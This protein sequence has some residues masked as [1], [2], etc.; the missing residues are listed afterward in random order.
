MLIF[1]GPQEAWAAPGRASWVQ[2]NLER[3]GILHSWPSLRSD[4]S[5]EC[6]R[7]DITPQSHNQEMREQSVSPTRQSWQA[8]LNVKH[9]P[10]ARKA[11]NPF[12]RVPAL[13]PEPSLLVRQSQQVEK[14]WPSFP[15]AN[16]RLL[17]YSILLLISVAATGLPLSETGILFIWG[18]GR[19]ECCSSRAELLARYKV[20]V[21]FSVHSRQDCGAMY[22]LPP[23]KGHY[24]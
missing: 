16:P 13:S 3:S 7:C 19:R 10:G 8:I 14:N 21:L 5:L 6:S 9:K 2:L 15:T 11:N 23:P 24:L 17:V 12:T 20:N 18:G 4:S 22:F 1:E